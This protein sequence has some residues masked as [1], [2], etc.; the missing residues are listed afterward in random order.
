M[1]VRVKEEQEELDWRGCSSGMPTCASQQP[2]DGVADWLLD[3]PDGSDLKARVLQA[4]S[5]RQIERRIDVGLVVCTCLTGRTRQTCVSVCVFP[6]LRPQSDLSDR[7]SQR[8]LQPS[9]HALPFGAAPSELPLPADTRRPRWPLAGWCSTEVLH[10]FT[11]LPSQAERKR[12]EGRDRR[13]RHS[14]ALAH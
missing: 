4:S 11:R 10:P 14:P 5:G 7:P 1:E 9:A 3:G 6:S 2:V 12:A 8:I 13:L